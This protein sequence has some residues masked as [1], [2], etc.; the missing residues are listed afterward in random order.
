MTYA[1]AVNWLYAAVPNFQRDGGGKNYKIGLEGPE[2]LWNYLGRPSDAIPTIHIA[3]TNGKGSSAHLISAGLQ[4]MGCKV[5]V[6]S[7][8]HLFNF[9][10]RAKIGTEMV[11]ESFVA[12]WVFQHKSEVEQKGNSFFELTLMLAMSWFEEQKVDWIVL[13]TG[14]GGRLDATTICTPEICLITNIGLDHEEWLGSTR[15]AIAREKAGIIKFGIPVVLVEQDHETA[16]VFIDVAN[17]IGAPLFWAEPFYGSTDLA[18]GY[19]S[20]NIKGAAAVLNLLHPEYGA[21]WSDGFERVGELTGFFGRWSII[22]HSPRVVCDTGHN[23][24]A[25][26][27]LIEQAERECRGRIHW[28]LGA[29]ADKD[30]SAILSLLPKTSSYYFTSCSSPRGKKGEELAQEANILGLNSSHFTDVNSA[31]K[32]A[33]KEAANE[34][35][36]FIGG[37]TFVIA[38]LEL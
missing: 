35:L 6:F 34:D 24:H 25:F 32:A 2:A 20:L 33:R 18:G 23:P 31:L 19:Q 13:E 3:G 12:Q 36:I 22:G 17:T 8:P 4:S 7:S 11:P 10:E 21:V 26:V 38:D 1:E 30:S 27:H 14:M 37:S 15:A 9:R 5:G 28:I 16:P 29:A